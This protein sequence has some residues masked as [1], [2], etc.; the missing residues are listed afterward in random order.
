MCVVFGQC[1]DLLVVLA[2][3]SERCLGL[4]ESGASLKSRHKSPSLEV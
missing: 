1:S 3:D 4:D 2:A